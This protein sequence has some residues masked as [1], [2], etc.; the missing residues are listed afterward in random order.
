M[1][2]KLSKIIVLA[3][4]AFLVAAPM[5]LAQ[6]NSPSGTGAGTTGSSGD[7]SGTG[8]GMSGS[9][10]T[11]STTGTQSPSM[12]TMS[13][14]DA[15][16]ATVA[17]VNHQQHT[18]KLRMQGGET[19]ELKVPEQSLMSLSKGDSVQVSIRKAEGQSGMQSPKQQSQPESGTGTTGSTVPKAR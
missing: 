10:T 12:G 16:H 19:V 6:S 15:I 17:D 7:R 5:V 2:S 14:Q 18:V 8:T 1:T 3:L 13:A 11:G 4:A 9:G